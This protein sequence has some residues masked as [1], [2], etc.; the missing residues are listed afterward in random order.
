MLGGKSHAACISRQ[1]VQSALGHRR[2][3]T[4]VRLPVSEMGV[5]EEDPTSVLVAASQ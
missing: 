1:R 2:V 3:A 4:V 5:F